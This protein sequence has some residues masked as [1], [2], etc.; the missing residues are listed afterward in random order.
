MKTMK[1]NPK[2]CKPTGKIFSSVEE[3]KLHY[4]MP[5]LPT[6]KEINSVSNLADEL[7]HK[8]DNIYYQ[9]KN[10]KLRKLMIIF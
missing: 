1:K 2:N 3:L 10:S 6:E 5:K 7:N 9:S 4:N 8:I